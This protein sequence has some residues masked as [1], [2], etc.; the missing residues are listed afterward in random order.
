MSFKL[1][2]GGVT[3]PAPTEKKS[4][5]AGLKETMAKSTEPVKDTAQPVEE[6]KKMGLAALLA[7][8]T[9]PV[10]VSQSVEPEQPPQSLKEN[11]TI[12][13]LANYVFEEQPQTIGEDAVEQYRTM[14][15][16]LAIAVGSEVR[17]NIERCMMFLKEHAEVAAILKPEDIGE[18]VRSA[19]KAYGVA[20]AVGRASKVKKETKN[21]QVDD[22]FA[23]LDGLL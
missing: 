7:K 20:A 15:Q 17:T 13:D 3:P 14:Q 23:S 11:P 8:K 18:I 5:F 10:A 2:I 1:N 21:K 9:P 16:Q 19:K 6:P 12:D 4:A 22:V